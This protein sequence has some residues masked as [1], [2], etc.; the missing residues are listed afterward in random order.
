[1]MA[2]C[3]QNGWISRM[4]DIAGTLLTSAMALAAVL[5]LI[6]VIGRA[7]R[8]SA[9]A[10][11]SKHARP[12]KSG[13]FLIVKESITLDARRRLHLIQ[14][15]DREVLLLTGGPRDLVLGCRGSPHPP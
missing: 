6:L 5:G 9:L 8:F 10:Q 12:A 7:L 2:S 13:Q 15:G 3:L 14:H 1:M 4:T 11:F